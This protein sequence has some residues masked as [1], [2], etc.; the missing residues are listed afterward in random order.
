MSKQT[1]AQDNTAFSYPDFRD[2]FLAA[3]TGLIMR[4]G[5][6]IAEEGHFRAQAGNLAQFAAAAERE[7]RKYRL[8]AVRPDTGGTL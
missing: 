7:M 3:V 1:T 6:V 4:Q 2:A 8:G 5:M